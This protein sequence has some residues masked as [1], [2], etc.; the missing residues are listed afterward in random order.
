[1]DGLTGKLTVTAAVA[2]KGGG[3]IIVTKKSRRC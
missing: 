2:Q 3:T 1:M